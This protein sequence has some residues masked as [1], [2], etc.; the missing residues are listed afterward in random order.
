MDSVQM[1]PHVCNPP[2]DATEWYV[3]CVCV[4]AMYRAT[5]DFFLPYYSSLTEM[6]MV[7]SQK[8]IS[9]A[10]FPSDPSLISVETTAIKHKIMM[11]FQMR[12]IWVS[13]RSWIALV[14]LLQCFCKLKVPFTKTGISL[15][16]IHNIYLEPVPSLYTGCTLYIILCTWCGD[17]S[18]T[19]AS[20]TINLLYTPYIYIYNV[21]VCLLDIQWNLWTADTLGTGLLSI[22][23]RL[24]LS[25]RSTGWPHPNLELVNR[26]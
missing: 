23:E 26:F 18:S 15:I 13:I 14:L 7:L 24:S 21:I 11:P 19:C 8:L 5:L 25:Q 17:D 3:E 16:S 2:G 10:I 6:E 12:W 22:V 1:N 4:C 9:P 20:C